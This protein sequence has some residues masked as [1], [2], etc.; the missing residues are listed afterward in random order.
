MD[1]S[2]NPLDIMAEQ[3]PIMN[4]DELIKIGYAIIIELNARNRKVD[5]NA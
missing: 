5:K 2:K 1:T 3:I 4:N